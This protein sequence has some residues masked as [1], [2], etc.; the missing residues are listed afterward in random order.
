MSLGTEHRSQEWWD[1]FFIGMA[2]Y[3]ATP[4]RDPSTQTGAVVV[5]PDRTVVS[6]G[7]N[8]FARGVDDAPERYS[9][10]EIKYSMVVHC[11]AN[12][13]IFAHRNI[14]GCTLYTHPFMSCSRCAAMVIQAGI[15]R[16]VAPFSQ[17]ERW[18]ADFKLSTE[19]FDE[20]GVE[21]ILLDGPKG[22]YKYLS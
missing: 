6:M 2:K 7:Y 20:A 17:N 3:I 19:Q 1:R 22:G 21:I 4:S 18:I 11:E 14:A 12:A 10:R 5:A 15:K 8:G 9:N 13:I 16:V